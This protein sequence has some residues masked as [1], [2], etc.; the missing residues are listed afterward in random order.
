MSFDWL[1]M[2]MKESNDRRSPIYACDCIDYTEGLLLWLYWGSSK[3][4]EEYIWRH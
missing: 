4:L 3:D 2:P 1:I